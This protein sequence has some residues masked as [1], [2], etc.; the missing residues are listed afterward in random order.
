MYTIII[1]S[2]QV[3]PKK[4]IRQ[5]N[6]HLDLKQSVDILTQNL[7]FEDIFLVASDYVS[8]FTILYIQSAQQISYI[9]QTKSVTE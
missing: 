3:E 8:Y 1:Y 6:N 7:N 4:K 2:V 9:V 5:I